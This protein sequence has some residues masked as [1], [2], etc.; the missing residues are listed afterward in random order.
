MKNLI[1]HNQINTKN[2][3]LVGNKALKL[4]SLA[5]AGIQIAEFFVIPTSVFEKV[6]ANKEIQ[7][8]GTELVFHEKGNLGKNHDNLLKILE[9]I[10]LK[11]SKAKFPP[12]IQK[13]ILQNFDKLNTEKVAVRSSA[14]C[15]DN[16]NSSFAGQ[17]ESYLSCFKDQVFEAILKCYRSVF[18]EQVLMYCTYHNVDFSKIKMAVI[19]QEM[20]SADKGGVIFTKDLLG[21][22]DRVIIEAAKGLGEKV[23]SGSHNSQKIV[24]SKKSG[25]PIEGATYFEDSILSIKEAKK[26]F[27]IALKI[28][29]IFDCPQDIEW[30]IEKDK[31]YI[32]QS[33]PIT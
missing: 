14:T 29:E 9:K 5:K 4:A 6:V 7:K 19:V 33:R 13:Q 17:F 11:I 15:E 3:N 2:K 21:N 10:N 26:L 1:H 27:Q 23:V 24:F 16:I 25:K 20:I 28:E 22:G 12:E 32:L 30:A 31:I 8:L 18:T